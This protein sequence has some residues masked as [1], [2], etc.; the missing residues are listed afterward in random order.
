MHGGEVKVAV[1]E[2]ANDLFE[3]GSAMA[4]DRRGP[5]ETFEDA[6]V[7]EASEFGF[8]APKVAK[9]GGIGFVLCGRTVIDSAF[10]LVRVDNEADG[11][12]ISDG[13]TRG[14]ERPRGERGGGDGDV[15]DAIS[16]TSLENIVE[17]LEVSARK[18]VVVFPVGGEKEALREANVVVE[19]VERF[20]EA[21]DE[22]G[23][24]GVV[25][26]IS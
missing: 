1:E 5:D 24:K 12:V 4:F 17:F 2:V 15:G 22:G 8:V 16:E 7:F 6:A 21:Q 23:V 26:R 14:S 18:V 25:E 3:D 19:A 20:V 13:R 11:D 9:G 10:V